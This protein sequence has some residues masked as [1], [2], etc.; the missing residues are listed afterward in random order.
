MRV[1]KG[2]KGGAERIGRAWS[3][4]GRFVFE[5]PFCLVDVELCNET[6]A[7]T[8]EHARTR[9]QLRTHGAHRHDADCK[10]SL[11]MN[12]QKVFTFY[13]PALTL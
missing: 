9:T 7:N 3:V 2:G 4:F 11:V 12:M 6:H 13:F 8:R 10:G 5:I 1:D